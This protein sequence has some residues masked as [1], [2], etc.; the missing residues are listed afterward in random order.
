[1]DMPPG[2]FMG[3]NVVNIPEDVVLAFCSLHFSGNKDPTIRW[4]LS[5]NVSHTN[6]TVTSKRASTI[7]TAFSV[8][9]T[10]DLDKS[11]LMVSA[12]ASVDFSQTVGGQ[13]WRS[14]MIR[15]NCEWI[16]VKFRLMYMSFSIS[17]F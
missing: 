1:M 17:I 7:T 3:E 16:R 10:K 6:A 5:S 12:E 8:R 15:V 13:S 9:P 4:S 14:Q 2:G 11:T